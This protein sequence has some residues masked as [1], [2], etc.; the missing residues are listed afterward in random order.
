MAAGNRRRH[1]DP[2]S[3]RRKRHPVHRARASQ[4]KPSRR[5]TTAKFKNVEGGKIDPTRAYS[6]I[7]LPDSSINLFF[8]DGPISRA[9]AFEGLLSD[10]ERFADRLM[11]GFSDDRRGEQLMH[12]A[13][14]GETYGSP[15]FQ[16]EMAL[17]YALHHI[18]SKKL[19]QL[20]NYGEFLA[21]YPA[22]ARSRNP[23]EHCLEL[24]RTAS[25][26][27]RSDCGC[28]SGGARL[29]PGLARALASRARLAARQAH[30][31]HL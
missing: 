10:G 16:G 6:A 31:A 29:E 27:W 13:T 15:S 20:T 18:E 3:P 28:N 5:E 24:R 23:R 17:T 4:A 25:S 22:D 12:I 30:R 1:R 9:V 14:D 19:A 8:Y 11:S 26:R 21:E 2:R 7:F